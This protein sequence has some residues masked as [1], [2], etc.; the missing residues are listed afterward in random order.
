MYICSEVMGIG[1]DLSPHYRLLLNRYRWV[2]FIISD[3]I[4]YISYPSKIRNNKC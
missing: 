4:F 3:Y 1:P 2:P